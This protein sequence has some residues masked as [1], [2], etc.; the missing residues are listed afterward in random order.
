MLGN[1]EHFYP[2]QDD[3]DWED[4]EEEEEQGRENGEGE[5]DRDMENGELE[6][7][8]EMEMTGGRQS[9]EGK[10]GEVVKP[11][12]IV[13][14]RQRADRALRP[15]NRGIAY[16]SNQAL[17]HHQPANKQQHYPAAANHQPHQ[18]GLNALQKRRALMERSMTTVA[19]MDDTFLTMMVFRIGIPDIKQT[20]CLQFDQDCTV[21]SAKQQIICSLNETLWDVYNYGLFQPAGDGRDAKFLEEER[22]LRDYSQTFEKGVPYL[23]FRYKTRV[24]KQTNLDEKALSKLSTKASLKK[25]LD[26]IQTGAIEKMAKVLDKGLDSNFH[27]PDSG[28]TPL[29]IAMQSGLP[30][31]GIRLL[32][33]GGSHLD[34]RSRDGFTPVHKAVRAHNHAGLMALL[35]LGASPNYRDRYGLTPLYHTVLTGGDTSC[36]ETLLYYRARLG[37]KDENG[38]DESHQHR[39]EEEFG[40]EEIHKAC[41]NGFAQHLEHLLF[42]GAETSSQNASGNTALHISALYNKESCVRVLLYRGANKEAKNKLGQTPFQLAIMSGHFELGEIFKNHK[43]SDIVPFL[44]SPKYVPKRKE[45]AYTLPLPSLHSHPLLRA[46]SDNS[47]TQSDPLALPNKAA[48]NPNPGQGQRRASIGMRSSSS[49]RTRTRS[50]SRG[51]GGQSDTEER[52]RQPRGRQGATSVGSGGDQMKRMYS[53]VPGRVYMATRAYSAGGDKELSLNKGDRVKVLSVGE[54]GYWEGT[55]KGRTGWFPSDC[56]EEVAALSKD[57][58][59]ETRSEKAKRKLFRNVT[60]GAYDGTDGPSDYIIKEKTVLLQKKDNEG[61]GFVLRGAKAQTPIEEFTPT[62][63]FPALQYLESV[64]EGGVAWRA[65]LRMGDFLIE[66]NGQNV[67]KVG[68]RQVV[69]MIRQ[70]SNSLMVKVVMVARNPE[71]EDTARKRAPQQTKR[72]TPPAIA[73]RSKSMTSELEDMVDKAASPWKKKAEYESSLGPDKKRTVYQMALNKLDEILSAAQHTITPDNQGQRGH[74]GKRDRSKSVVPNVSNEQPY[75]HQSSVSM[76]Q[77]GPGFG[78][79]QAHF[80]PGHTQ[81]AVMIRQKSIGVTEEERQYLHPP[82][83]KLARSLSVPGPE[84]IPPPPNTSAPEPPLSAGPHPVRGPAMP[85]PPVSQAHY[86]LQSQPGHATQAGWERGGPG[87]MNQQAMVPTLRRQSDGLGVREPEAPRRGGGKMGGLRRG[88]SSA[89][90]PTSAK[91]KAPPAPQHHPH[92][93]NREQGGGVGRGT[94]RRGGRGALMKQSKVEDGLRQ[95]RGKGV[96]AKEK[97]SIPIPTIIVKAPST[98]SSGRSS[99]GSSMEAEPLRHVEDHTSADTTSDSPNTSL[100]S[101]LTPLPPQPPTPTSLPSST[102]APSVSSQQNLENLDYTSTYG[103]AFG[104]GGARRERERF[105]DMRRKSASFFLSTEEDIQGEAEGGVEEGG[106]AIGARIQPLQGIQMEVPTPR[107]RPSKSIDEGMFSGDSYVHYSSSMPPAF[108]LPEYSSPVLGQDGQP[109][110]APSMYGT[111]ATTTFIHPLTGK[112]LDPSSPLGL[113]LAARERA[114]KDDRR[115]RREERHFGRQLSTVGAFP[116]PVQTPTP[117]LFATPT[118]SAYTSPVSVHLSSPTATTSPASMSRPQ[119]PRILRLGGGG[120]ERMERDKEG[121]PREGLR[122]RF[123]ED[124]TSQ[125]STQYYPQSPREREREKEV[126]DSRPAPPMQPPPP[127]VQPAPRRPSFLQM[128]SAPNTSYVP[129]YTVPTAPAQ[130]HE[131]RAGAGGGLGLMVLPPPAPSIDAEDEFV[132]SDPL[133]PPIQFANGKKERV[134]EYPQQHQHRSQHSAAVAP[135]PP[136]S[137]PSSKHSN[138]P[139][140]SSQGG[141]SAASS[142]T[143]YDSE[144]AN[145]TQSALSPSY[146]SPQIFPPPPATTNTATPLPATSLHRP[147]PMSHSHPYYGSSNDPSVGGHITAQDRGTAT[148]TYATTTMTSTAAPTTTT[149]PGSSDYSMTMAGHKTGL[150]TGGKAADHTHHPT[151]TPKSGDWQDAVVDSGIEELDSHSSSDHHLEMLGLS[152]LRGERGGIGGDG[153]GEEGERGS[154]HQ[155]PCT[156]Y[157]GGQTFEL[158]SAKLANPVFPRMTHYKEGGGRCPPVALRRQNS[159]NP[160]PLQLHRPSNPDDVRL[161]VFEDE[162]KRKQSRSKMED[163]FNTSLAA[164]L[165]RQI[166]PRSVNWVEVGEHE[167]GGDGVQRGGIVLEGRRLHSPLAGVKASIINELS[168]KL[169]HMKS[170]DDWSHTPKSP[171]MHRYSADFTDVFHSPP[172]GHSTSPLPT[173]SPQHRQILT[174]NLSATPSVSPSSQVPIQ[175]NWTRSPSPQMPTSPV[176]AHP[177]HSPTYCPYPTSPKH[178]SKL[179]GQTFDFQCSPTKEMR[180]SVSR[181]RAPSPLIYNTEQSNPTPP[182]PSSLPILPITPIYNNPFDFPG[183][184]TPPSPGIP[185]GDTYATSTPPI[186]SPSGVPSANPLLVSR[187][188]SPTHFLSGASSP[189]HLPLSPSCLNYPHLTPPAP[190]KPFAVKPLP[191][192]TKYDVADWLAYLNLGEHRERFIDNEIDGSHLPSLTKDDFLDLGVT[193]VG[194]RMNIERALKKLTDRRL[195]SPLHVTTSLQD[196]D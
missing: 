172:S 43:D 171:T 100:P 116:T 78:Y 22:A 119:S 30:V 169:Q 174:P 161:E 141:D 175:R 83:M 42:Y 82:A 151:V 89:T 168:S 63:A 124:R 2:G 60:V 139:Q 35:S 62:P 16:M 122:V 99:Q 148:I 107:L 71:L 146:P 10:S 90:P 13:V 14:G 26:Y 72:L 181:R 191:Y 176:H 92:M 41:Q 59:S 64:D 67:V 101:P 94:T 103:T 75:E 165:E 134:Q 113:A 189:I 129:Q 93:A 76:V 173:S 9:W 115:T 166:D 133:P 180:S 46:N 190:A 73:L 37:T 68:H 39:D 29:S 58:R 186:F 104:G 85:I 91:P 108:G 19:P 170:M 117:S 184:L 28:E 47:M 178:R 49:P 74:G 125:Y 65:G 50:P 114:L 193:R 48:T 155:D 102:V 44:E 38:W 127:P 56:V 36:C 123:S 143:S 11:A 136:P 31:E 81:H 185:L 162:R 163:G 80:Q 109:K 40:M 121:A 88:Y 79:N 5:D 144:V 196:T 132:F 18:A 118:Q 110:S 179:R 1:N 77:P 57:N 194:H 17:L 55:A 6:G 149:S 21:W 33:Q 98:S 137:L 135:P 25:F 111:Q 138:A 27:D 128:D 97:S 112:V 183:P 160:A 15:G 4:E 95:H 70:G 187:S 167:Q 8:E 145:L 177:P 87:G 12:A 86:Q 51:R 159:T 24:Y 45:S 126:Y 131:T 156:T 130:T 7:L 140:P 142:L 192:W 150:S 188:L 84:E 69:N 61:F 53:A 20:R 105:R 66:V 147:Q 195:S 23:E 182:R 157:S 96:A 3:K 120:G 106:G 54:G 158:H 164:C 32:V 34:F 153:R 152:G 52:H 154:E